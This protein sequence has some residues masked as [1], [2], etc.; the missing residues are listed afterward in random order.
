MLCMYVCMYVCMYCTVQLQLYVMY[1]YM[2]PGVRVRVEHVP[3]PAVHVPGTQ[4]NTWYQVKPERKKLSL[5]PET[6]KKSQT[7]KSTQRQRPTHQIILPR[8]I[9]R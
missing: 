9:Q 2:Y 6:E 4:G 7:T 8:P 1:V 5:K 3:Y